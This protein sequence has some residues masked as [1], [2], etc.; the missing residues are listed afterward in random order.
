[1]K[2]VWI[3][4]L[5][6]VLLF[7]CESSTSEIGSDFFTDGVL[8]LSYIDSSTVELSTIQLEDLVTNSTTRLLVG[9][10]DDEMLGKLTAIPFFQITPSGDVNFK[11]ENIEYDHASLLLPL[12]HYSYYD[13]LLPLTLKVHRVV[14]DIKTEK[15]YLFNSSIFKIEDEPIGS[16]TLRPKPHADSVEINLS[17]LLGREIFE[18]ATTNSDELTAANFPKYIRGFAIVPDTTMSSC[19]VGLKTNPQLKVYY[20]DKRVTPTVKRH[21][22][23]NV[24]STSSLYFTHISFN[25]KNTS[26]ET[27]PSAKE[28]LRSSLTNDRAY[29]QSGAG[30]ALRVD[31]PYLRALK[32]LDNF[33]VTHAILEVR[34]VHKSNNT[35]AKLPQH[36]KAVKADKRNNVY[37][38]VEATASLVE[39]PELERDLYYTF[40]ITQFVKEQMELQLL[41]ENALIFTTDESNYPVSADRIY[42]AAPAYEYKTRLRIYFATVNN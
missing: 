24:T 9:T 13:T 1:M 28:R 12:D 33:F 16:L 5:G 27:M 2:R 39:D 18:K 20:I 15:G 25:R 23:F 36:L 31:M 19:I 6:S 34:V 4:V 14:A 32:Q 29:I 41:N 11:G 7:S 10:H 37:Q 40:D 3:L 26:L 35:S 22:G 42:L 21:I 38:E 30:L 8:D 17:D